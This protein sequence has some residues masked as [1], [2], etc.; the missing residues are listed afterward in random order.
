MALTASLVDGEGSMM[1]KKYYLLGTVF[2]VLAV[3]APASAFAAIDG[4]VKVDGGTLMG[5]PSFWAYGVWMFRG[6]PY[7]APPVGDLRW[8]PPQPAAPWQ[9][10]RVADHFGPAC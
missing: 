3:F 7:A 6:I 1:M 5:V 4:E 10:V 9:G 2:A 8:K